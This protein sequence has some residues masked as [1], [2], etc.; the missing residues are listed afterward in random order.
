MSSPYAASPISTPLDQATSSN[1]ASLARLTSLATQAL[2][3]LLE[4]QRLA[5]L[6]R[7]STSPTQGFSQS[8]SGI[9]PAPQTIRNLKLIREGTLDYE[10]QQMEESSTLS[11]S[12]LRS[13]RREIE[14]ETRELRD[15]FRRMRSMLA[16]P[17]DIVEELEELPPS[18]S[19][20]PPPE[21]MLEGTAQGL[22]SYMPYK[23]DPGALERGPDDGEVYQMN[24]QIMMNQDHR[25]DHLSSSINRQRDISLNINSELEVHTGLLEG[26]DTDLDRTGDRLSRARRQLDKFSRGMKGNGASI[27]IVLLITILLLLIVIFKT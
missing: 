13:R 5:S 7:T 17:D 18:P 8:Q 14:T 20:S 2:T 10:R 11:G 16:Q 24:E 4:R 19:P 27:F 9:D 12:A 22:S 23:D 1:S 3:S 6:S 15:Q 21:R 26:L 25:L